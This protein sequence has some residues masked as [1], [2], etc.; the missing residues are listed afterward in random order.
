MD[1]DRAVVASPMA[2]RGVEHGQGQKGQ[3]LEH[4]ERRTAASPAPHRQ[5]LHLDAGKLR[6]GRV[7]WVAGAENV[8]L[9]P[10]GDEGARLAFD[11]G[12]G[13]R[14]WTIIRWRCAPCRCEPDATYLPR[15]TDDPGRLDR[16]FRPT[17][18][19]YPSTPDG[20]CSR[21]SGALAATCET[22]IRFT[23][24]LPLDAQ[25]ARR[26]PVRPHHGAGR[27]PPLSGRL[28]FR[29]SSWLPGRR[30]GAGV[31]VR[32]PVLPCAPSRG[33]RAGLHP[34]PR[35]PGPDLEGSPLF[36]AS[37]ET[38]VAVARHKESPC[39]WYRG[40]LPGRGAG[41]PDHS[42][43]AHLRARVQI[44]KPAPRTSSSAPSTTWSA[45]ATSFLPLASPPSQGH[46]YQDLFGRKMVR[47]ENMDELAAAYREAAAA[48]SR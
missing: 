23:R 40:G 22:I 33:E 1:L 3:V 6:V 41:H 34:R 44:G 16:R 10:M 11:R 38:L 17:R 42:Q 30:P 39:R 14:L 28:A 19:C 24:S 8:D 36:P 4:L 37:D 26:R 13:Q 29:P 12:S 31:A 7:V 43:G 20:G 27:R 21:W 25:P 32:G 45:T 48:G 15:N 5:T 2:A 9:D 46:L 47:V 35:A 18:Q